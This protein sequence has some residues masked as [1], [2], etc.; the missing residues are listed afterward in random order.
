MSKSLKLS[1]NDK[2]LKMKEQVI[3]KDEFVNFCRTYW[4]QDLPKS[5]TK[6]GYLKGLE[7]FVNVKL[8]ERT[9]RYM[10]D[11][12]SQREFQEYLLTFEPY[13]EKKEKIQKLLKQNGFNMDWKN[14]PFD[15]GFPFWFGDEYKGKIVPLNMTNQYR[16]Y[17][18]VDLDEV[19]KK[20]MENFCTVDMPLYGYSEKI[21]TKYGHSDF[22]WY[23][24]KDERSFEEF[25]A[26][27]KN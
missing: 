10:E 8:K 17:K 16:Y 2:F 18:G 20:I 15:D 27:L 4:M 9:Q 14:S 1:E 5:G 11:G 24:I 22:L 19:K 25:L 23:F 3:T 13:L 12:L 7:D 26:D 6:E 21:H